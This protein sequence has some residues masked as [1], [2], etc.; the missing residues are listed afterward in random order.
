MERLARE[1]DVNAEAAAEF[2]RDAKRLSQV[3]HPNL[4]QVRDVVVGTSTVL[5]VTD[6]VDGEVYSDIARM[7]GEQ[8]VPIPLAGSL[9]VVVDLL[10]GLSALHE[11]CDAKREPLRIVH[12]EVAPRNIVVGVDGRSVLV[13]PL[14]APAGPARQHSHEVLG[15]LAPEVLLGD[16]TADQRADVYGAGV[17][18]WEA[19]TGQRMHADGEDAGEIVMRLLGGRIEAPRPPIDAPW[20]APLAEAAQKAVSPDPTI[21]YANATEMLAAVRR[22]VGAR[23]APKLTVSALVEAVAGE[24]IRARNAALGAT[25][26]ARLPSESAWTTEAAAPEAATSPLDPDATKPPPSVPPPASSKPRLT[27]SWGKLRASSSAAA[28]ANATASTP[29]SSDRSDR[30]PLRSVDPTTGEERPARA[31]GSSDPAPSRLSQPVPSSEPSSADVVEVIEMDVP[32]DK[33]SRPV[34]PSRE[35]PPVP[36]PRKQL[37]AGPPRP[38]PVTGNRT[39]PSPD[40][41]WKLPTPTA[42]AQSE[43]PL[44]QSRTDMGSVAR[45]S[46]QPRSGGA[47]LRLAIFAACALVVGGGVW[48]LVRTPSGPSAET[49]DPPPPSAAASAPPVSPTTSATPPAP[50]APAPTAAAA[51]ATTAHSA[52]TPSPFDPSS[53]DDHRPAARSASPPAKPPPATAPAPVPAAAA[54]A[55]SS[56]HPKKR[57]YDPMGI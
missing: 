25:R 50:P 23:L 16:Q 46:P 55:A 54:P 42:D 12:A 57:V 40:D 9:R 35:P 33:P 4:V 31:P 32:P 18:L 6:W 45:V 26:T 20:A 49:I 43:L 2:M 44:T 41:P 10:E 13:H 5:L 53:T 3:R 39:G 1:P 30:T 52:D 8:G 51:T 14:R 36:P 21:R 7:A 24:R 17:L 37:S 15:Y 27:P 19:L 22:V 11:V 48:L 34:S 38:P 29:P 28:T 56:P 47:A